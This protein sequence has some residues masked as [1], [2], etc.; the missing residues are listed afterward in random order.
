[1]KLDFIADCAI[2]RLSEFSPD[3]VRRFRDELNNLMAGDIPILAVH[4]LPFLNAV[5]DCELILACDRQETGLKH[6]GPSQFTCRWSSATWDNIIGLLDPF[7]E[8]SLGFQ[9]LNGPRD[10]GLSWLI[11]KDGTW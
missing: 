11:S 7:V 2:L 4:E 3:E 5:S 6:T 1:M 9:W 10:T 8:G